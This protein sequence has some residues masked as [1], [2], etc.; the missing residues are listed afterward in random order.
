M[1]RA[2]FDRCNKIYEGVEG[3]P[4]P[5]FWELVNEAD[6]VLCK[7]LNKATTRAEIQAACNQFEKTFKALCAR[8]KPPL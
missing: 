1:V 2:A 7:A 8:V 6:D 5:K 3:A 4:T